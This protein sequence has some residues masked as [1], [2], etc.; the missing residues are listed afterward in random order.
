MT[1]VGMPGHGFTFPVGGIVP[2]I[3]SSMGSSGTTYNVNIQYCTTE[4]TLNH[5][6]LPSKYSSK[7]YSAGNAEWL[8]KSTHNTY[9]SGQQ[10]IGH[11][12][13][14]HLL[15]YLKQT[16]S[17]LQY[18]NLVIDSRKVMEHVLRKC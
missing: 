10:L 14:Q 5:N 8:T 3:F 11:S 6:T 7:L 4:C 13:V 17:L 15:G 18:L 2:V 9:F 12:R 16:E 1:T